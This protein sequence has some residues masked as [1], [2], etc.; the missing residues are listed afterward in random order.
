MKQRFVNPGFDTIFALSIIAFFLLPALVFGQGKRR[1]EIRINNGDTIVNG[2]NI[3]DLSAADR[4]RALKDID[5]FKNLNGPD[6]GKRK[7]LIERRMFGDNDTAA[8]HRTFKFRFRGPNGKDSMMT[9]NYR[10]APGREFRFEPKDFD[11]EPR[12]FEF[13]NFN[14]DMPRMRGMAMAHR[15]NNQSFSYTNTGSDG[16][17]THINFNASD[18]SPERTKKETGNEKADLQL[19]DLV[20]VPEFSSGKTMLS[21]SLPSR[22]S[23][24]VKLTDNDGKIIW[25]DKTSNGSFS[26]TFALGL[27]GVYL[28]EVKQGG[29]MALKRIVKEE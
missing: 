13:H 20:I 2:R 17:I 10:M 29:K 28:L 12:D 25:I 23:A 6:T 3:K 14:G 18:A 22:A 7:L 4:E 19:Q 8:G 9:F 27:N 26:K 5:G 16:M 11:A 21:F 15:R 1:I 24:E